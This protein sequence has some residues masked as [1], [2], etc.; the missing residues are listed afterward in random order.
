[1]GYSSAVL[2]AWCLPLYSLN[3]VSLPGFTGLIVL[4]VAFRDEAEKTFKLSTDA[5]DHPESGWIL[6][7]VSF[8]QTLNMCTHL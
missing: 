1:M 3:V 2:N 6:Y 7:T 4:L 5:S 8:W